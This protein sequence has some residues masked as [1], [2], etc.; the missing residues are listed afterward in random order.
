DLN[1]RHQVETRHHVLG[2]VDPRL[3]LGLNQ[4]AI[5]RS[6]GTAPGVDH[7]CEH[8]LKPSVEG[9]TWRLHDLVGGRFVPFPT[10]VGDLLLVNQHLCCHGYASA[11]ERQLVLKSFLRR[12]SGQSLR[13]G[14]SG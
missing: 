4:L 8:A 10:G 14:V 7:R 6:D 1:L 5:L 12:Q 2:V 13:A 9:I 3:Q 11:G